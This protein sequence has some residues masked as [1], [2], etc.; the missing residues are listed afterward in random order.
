MEKRETFAQALCDI[1]VKHKVIKVE[2]ARAMQ[3]AFKNSSKESF[4]DFLLE[5]SLVEEAPLLKALSDLY[6]VPAIDVVGY[7]FETFLLHKFPK[8]FLLR[9]RII[10]LQVDENI[11]IMV[12]SNPNDPDL[13]PEIGE[14]VSYDIQFYVGLGRDIEDSVKEF[15]EESLTQ[16]YDQDKVENDHEIEREA[17]HEL[18]LEEDESPKIHDPSANEDEEDEDTE[19]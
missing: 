18:L 19:L 9:K 5:E 16:G 11:L 12:A 8:D 7:F 4:D 1:L 2:E 17:Y 3:R 14:N 10:P 6:E 15:Y 13:L